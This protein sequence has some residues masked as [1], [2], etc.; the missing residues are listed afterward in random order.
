MVEMPRPAERLDQYPHELSGG[1]RQRVMIA[2]ALACE[3]KLLIADEPT[4][5]LDVTIQAQILDLIDDLRQRLRMAVVLITHDMGVIAGRTDRVVVM[6]AGKVAEEADTV[7]LFS[8]MRHPYSE[9]LLES[10]PKLGSQPGRSAA[11]HFRPAA[12]PLADHHQ[13]PLRPAL[14]V[15]HGSVPGRGSPARGRGRRV[16]PITGSPASTRSVTTWRWRPPWSEPED[17][18]PSG[19]PSGGVGPARDPPGRRSGQ[20]IPG[21]SAGSVLRRPD[22]HASRRCPMSPSRSGGARPSGWSASR[23]AARPP[24]AGCWWRW[25]GPTAG[26]IEFE[27]MTSCA[28][29]SR[30]LRRRRRDLQLMF[31]DPYAS[32][33]PRM[34]VGSDHPGAA[35]GPTGRTPPRSRTSGCAA[36]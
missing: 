29:R 8:R 13:L 11:Q 33:D 28:D 35:Q 6:Y 2:M 17:P 10:V 36:C 21:A 3:P 16:G 32:L 34:R 19:P 26:T 31:Q 30:Q 9:A 1:L 12:R 22:R 18:R 20:G 5:A 14:P 15:R 4:T 25:S 27:G 23:A 24:S 7:E